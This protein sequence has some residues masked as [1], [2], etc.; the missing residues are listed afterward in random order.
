MADVEESSG[1]KGNIKC[2][3]LEIPA[4]KGHD[5]NSVTK[6]VSELRETKMYLHC[7]PTCSLVNMNCYLHSLKYYSLLTINQI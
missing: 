1:F 7:N 5:M 4:F 6:R 3:H 2:F